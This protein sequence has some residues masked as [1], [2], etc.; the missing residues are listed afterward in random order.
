MIVIGE[1]LRAARALARIE[2]AD[3]ATRAGVSLGT[4]KRLEATVGPVSANVTTVDAVVRALEAAGVEF[5]NGGEPG[6]KLRK[7]AAISDADILAR[8][9]QNC[10]REGAAW[11]VEVQTHPGRRFVPLVRTMDEVGRQAH[12]ARAK[13]EL[14]EERG[15]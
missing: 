9:K 1:Q 15:R 3:L 10:A 11:D 8:A 5:T 7:Q 4:V 13:A 2:Q 6:V 12:L 14:A